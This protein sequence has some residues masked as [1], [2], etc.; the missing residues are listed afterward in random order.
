MKV[1][2]MEMRSDSTAVTSGSRRGLMIGTDSTDSSSSEAV[3][4]ST[5]TWME[6]VEDG[7]PYDS[8]SGRNLRTETSI[9]RR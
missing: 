1:T 5:S 3:Q 4:R 6:H 8:L 2:V 9:R 7:I